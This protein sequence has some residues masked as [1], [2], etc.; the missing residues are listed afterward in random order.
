[1][2][3]YARI[4]TFLTVLFTI[5]AFLVFSVVNERLQETAATEKPPVKQT[6]PA[7]MKPTPKEPIIKTTRA[8]LAAVGDVLLHRSVYN[9]A[10]TSDTSYD[11]SKMFTEVNPFILSADV[12]V[13]N[14][15]TMIGGVEIGLSD[16]PVFNSP[17]E[18]GDALKES[19]FDVVTLANNHTIDRGER[20]VL[21]G[22]ANWNAIGLVHTGAFRSFQDQKQIRT[23]TA[24]EI[25]FS[26]LSYTY[27]TNGIPV[28]KGKEYLVNVFDEAQM[29]QDIAR[30]KTVSDVVVVAMHW[31]QEYQVLPNEEQKRWAQWLSDEGVHIVLGSH[32]HVLQPPTWVKGK[33]G[34]KTFVAYSMGNFLSAQ[35][36]VD[37]LTGGIF[38]I[39]VVKTV[40]DGKVS[41]ALERPSAR[42][43]YN[44]YRN[45]RNF[46]LIPMQDVTNAQ[47]Q[48]VDQH[49]KQTIKRLR[50][51]IQDLRV[52]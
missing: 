51:Y 48:N 24:K 26:F 31:G 36:G 39:D 23:F 50:T 37:K 19:G 13:A 45:F 34:N 16:Y 14:Q 47:L 9:D 4:F 41:I 28:P 21:R 32:P 27:G 33:G 49:R 6:K 29:K 25:T 52:Y 8:T 35:I 46:K 42:V 38:T 30:A 44:H 7:Q 20:A 3:R 40:T 12:A 17:K 1:M 15:E 2:K 10:Q 22:L 11:F 18:I 43:V 5:T